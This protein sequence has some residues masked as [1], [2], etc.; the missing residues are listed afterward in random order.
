LEWRTVALLA[1]LGAQSLNEPRAGESTKN[2]MSRG[3]GLARGPS[4][5]RS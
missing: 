1:A 3:V 4:C 5:A 2:Q